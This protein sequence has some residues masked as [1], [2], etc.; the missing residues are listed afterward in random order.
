M[1]DEFESTGPRDEQPPVGDTQA[2]GNNQPA[3]PGRSLTPIHRNPGSTGESRP[4]EEEFLD[5]ASQS[6]QQEPE[7]VDAEVVGP[8]PEPIWH[9]DEP[10]KP[11]E[12]SAHILR[13]TPAEKIR[14]SE[15]FLR[16][17]QLFERI[18]QD[19]ETLGIVGE[20]DL[21]LSIYLNMTSRLLRRPLVAVIQ[22]SS[23]SGKSFVM[24]QVAEL[25]PPEVRVEWATSSPQALFRLPP[26]S[27]EHALVVVAERPHQRG[28][29]AVD[30]QVAWR[31]L[32]ATGQVTRQVVQMQRGG[33]RTVEITQRGPIAYLETTTQ[34]EIFFEDRNRMLVLHTDDSPE[35][36]R[37]IIESMAERAADGLGAPRAS[38]RQAVIDRHRTIQRL[39]RPARVVIPYAEHLM[40]PGDRIDDRRTFGHVIS[41]IEVIALLRSHQTGQAGN[42]LIRADLEDYRIAYRVLLPVL[43]QSRQ[44]ISGGALRVYRAIEQLVRERSSAA[45]TAEPEP[46]GPTRRELATQLG[47]SLATIR[48]RLAELRD[49][50]LV[51]EDRGPDRAL[52]CLLTDRRPET[53]ELEGLPHPNELE[54]LYTPLRRL[55]VV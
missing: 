50:G 15:E 28:P 40:L 27:L 3:E 7:Y 24:Q 52:H 10:V 54:A 44:P 51:Q 23:S 17:P 19:F 46:W 55:M 26:G 6:E 4:A 16:S 5:A 29:E 31:E 14:E 35:Q 20:Q 12:R 18:Q 21:S 33:Q 11:L 2:T 34:E 9:P 38:E 39:L 49:V 32:V 25:M 30:N 47:V 36:T 48:L 43:L 13:D 45:G 22:G 1:Q 37:R 42:D 8:P 41:M 53:V